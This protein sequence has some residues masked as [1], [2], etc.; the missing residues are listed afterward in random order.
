MKTAQIKKI[1]I[2]GANGFIGRYVAKFYSNLSYNVIGIG[3]G[4]WEKQE[5]VSWGISDWFECEINV[6]SLA[7]YAEN[8]FAII[9]CAGGSSVPNS[10][11]NPFVDYNKTLS[12]LVSIFEYITSCSPLTK[13]IYLSS[14]AVY[15]SVSKLPILES[16]NLNPVSPYGLHKKMAE[17][18]CAF[19][20]NIFNISVSVIRFFSVYGVGLKKQLL[21]DSCQ[22]ILNNNTNFFGTGLEV[23]DWLHI[24]DA[25][26]LIDYALK[27]ASKNCPVVNGG[28]GEGVE[29]I[30]L[31]NEIFL[32]LNHSDTP[33][34]IGSARIGDPNAF[35]ADINL[36]KNW[37]W[38]PKINW[39][40]GVSEYVK[41]FRKVYCDSSRI[42]C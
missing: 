8:S 14:A 25:V 21:W 6:Q 1:L 33:K 30:K 16:S 9:H 36:A 39:H 22:K 7:K 27:F 23:R 15:G 17:E 35:V 37:G 10:F 5:W 41:W 3:H 12:P 40:D 32:L 24:E 31:L 42:S 2:T 34:F 13:L 29:N 11:L 28:F 38:V 4:K 19:Y 18:L 26:N 20:A